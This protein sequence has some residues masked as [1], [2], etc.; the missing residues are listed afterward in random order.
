VIWHIA[1]KDWKLLWPMVALVTA[2]QGGLEWALYGAGLFGEDPAAGALLRPLTMA[3][4]V[5]IAALVVAVVQQD[6]IP[7]VDQDWLV[8]PIKRTQL[9]LAKLSFAAA[10]VCV[11]MLLFNVADALATGFALRPSIEAAVLK[12]LFVLATFVVPLAAL[13]AAT[14]NMTELVILGA[15]L[16]VVFSVTL[17][18]SALVSG[19]DWCPTCN[20]GVSW[21]QHMVEHAGVLAGACVVLGIQY[22]RRGTSL[23]RGVCIAGAALL[24][25]VQVPWRWAFALEQQVAGTPAAAGIEVEIAP[26]ASSAAAAA[27]GGG[28]SSPR[29]VNQAVQY[30]RRRVRRQDAPVSIEIPLHVGAASPDDLILADRADITLESTDG[31]VLYRGSNAGA[32]ATLL[33]P[34]N[35][36]GEA[37]SARQPLDL[38]GPAFRAARDRADVR[39][40]YSLTLMRRRA[41]Y[42]LAA[43]D[44][45][46]QTPEVGRCATVNDRNMVYLRCKTIAQA[47]FCYS[48]TLVSGDGRHNPVVLKCTPDYRRHVP[49]FRDLLG[50]YGAD[51]PLRDRSG[52]VYPLAAADLGSS[53]VVF[54]VFEEGAHFRRTLAAPGV[55]LAAWR[56]PAG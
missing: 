47:P 5:G 19:A 1:K 24:V 42:R 51:L 25:F 31:K 14:R 54:K 22:Y 48:A 12:E 3:W 21:L 49:G 23:A 2:I 9:L 29:D 30:V 7:G 52:T 46:L 34:P 28:R 16:M 15:L 26:D 17:S 44:G 45:E 55:A 38:P 53:Y 20:S 50:F 6:P 10:A 18:L 37:G 13:A 56:A 40:D 11:P 35:A 41:E 36:A 43:L 33:T 32:L 4:F 27:P 8:R 39:L